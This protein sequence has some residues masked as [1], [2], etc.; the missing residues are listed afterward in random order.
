MQRGTTYVKLVVLLGVLLATGCL[1]PEKFT[2]DATVNKDKSYALTFKGTM[3]YLPYRMDQG[4][5]VKESPERLAAKEAEMAS[6][7]KELLTKEGDTFKK[8]RYVGNGVFDIE[9]TA[10]GNL[11]ETYF[12][13]S[14]EMQILRF[15]PENDGTITIQGSGEDTNWNE[16]KQLGVAVDGKFSLKTDA[17]VLEHNAGKTPS[18][19]SKAYVWEIGPGNRPPHMV[20]KSSD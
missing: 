6:I 7:A 12:F 20:L 4:K 13:P 14:R 15:V 19:F 3:V 17:E 16:L 11:T 1:V 9:Y 5:A 10:A 8:V 2:S 18:L